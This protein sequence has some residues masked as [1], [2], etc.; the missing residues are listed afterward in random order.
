M[1][2]TL[3]CMNTQEQIKNSVDKLKKIALNS[4]SYNKRIRRIEKS[5]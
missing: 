3:F 2:I 1:D 5:A 4:I